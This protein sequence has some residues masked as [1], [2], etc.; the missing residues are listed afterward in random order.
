MP[1]LK[2]ISKK[3]LPTRFPLVSSCVAFLML[4][5]FHAAGWIWG[6]AGTCFAVLWVACFYTAFN[7]TQIDLLDEG[8]VA[9]VLRRLRVKERA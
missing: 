9:D 8:V 3:N 1:K 5:R 6:V 4:E 7:E 2:V